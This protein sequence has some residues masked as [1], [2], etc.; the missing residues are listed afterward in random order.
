[1]TRIRDT[2]GKYRLAR[3][4]RVGGSCQVW[5]AVDQET[6][7]RYAL[8]MLKPELAKNKEEI[9]YLRHEYEVAGD[10]KHPTIIRFYG[11]ET[12]YH[13]PFLVLELF[14]AL[15]LKQVL[16][17][18]PDPIAHIA[19]KVIHQL[20][21]GLHYMHEKGW[22]HCDVKPDNFLADD[23]GNVK[24]IDFTIS[25]RPKRS[26]LSLIGIRAPIKGTRSY[27][28]PEQIRGQTLDGRS[29]VYSFGCVVFELL[30]GRTPFTGSN[31]NEL[32]ER[33][34]KASIPSA[35]V[36]NKNITRDCADLLRRMMA[37]KREARPKSMWE[38][39]Q[40]F[41][42][43]QIF[44]RKPPIPKRKLSELDVGPV[45]DADQLKQL[46]QKPLDEQDEDEG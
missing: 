34:L 31:P 13:A 29:D 28:S 2:V 45:T 30:C 39:L 15:N 14:S 42:N 5:E 36:Y 17:E 44:N 25:Q 18:G 11:F 37:K 19:E 43:I 9:G 38:V 7:E 10:L 12:Q 4:I 8:K 20:T 40:E 32:L 24:L 16:R 21:H 1:M 41:R 22:I 27:M 3:L 35:V 46:P 33:H 6:N 23:D 26:L